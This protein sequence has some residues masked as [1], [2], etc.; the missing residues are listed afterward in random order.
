[1]PNGFAAMQHG[2]GYTPHPRPDQVIFVQRTNSALGTALTGGAASVVQGVARNLF[3]FFCFH[4]DF[5]WTG[6]VTPPYSSGEQDQ[7]GKEWPQ[8]GAQDA[9]L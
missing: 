1:L 9:I 4:W 5:G 8:A 7:G 3:N 2:T 6:A